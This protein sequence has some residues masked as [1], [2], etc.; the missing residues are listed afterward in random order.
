MAPRR[1]SPLALMK[2]TS[3][4]RRPGAAN[5]GVIGHSI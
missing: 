1:T 4:S 2:L 3:S 5:P